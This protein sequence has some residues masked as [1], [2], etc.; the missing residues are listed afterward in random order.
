MVAGDGPV[1]RVGEPLAKLAILDIARNPVD[2]LVE[3][4][5]TRLDL[6]H[7][8]EPGGHRLVDQRGGA[9]SAVR[10]GVHVAFLLEEDR[11]A[12]LRDGGERSVAGAQVAQD[13]QAR[14]T[15]AIHIKLC[16]MQAR[17]IVAMNPP[18]RLRHSPLPVESRTL[19]TG[20]T[21]DPLR[22]S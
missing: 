10:V 7:G 11:A 8:H 13:R 14:L 6:G 22:F 18:R 3:F 20:R 12:F 1:A 21:H 9:T 16:T 17:M 15:D 4:Q 5:Q 19:T 2:L